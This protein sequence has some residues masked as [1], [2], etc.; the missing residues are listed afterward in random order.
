MEPRCPAC[1]EPVK[2][3]VR[4]GISYEYCS[5]PT[6]GWDNWP[7]WLRAEVAENTRATLESAVEEWLTK[8]ALGLESEG[9]DNG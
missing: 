1:G 2:L 4:N 9:D 8:R 6:C 5:D 3:L 7:G